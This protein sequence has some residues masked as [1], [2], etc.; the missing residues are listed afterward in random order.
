MLQHCLL[1]KNLMHG[2][3][4]LRSTQTL[5]HYA[6]GMQKQGTR[7]RHQACGVLWGGHNITGIVANRKCS[8]LLRT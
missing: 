6:T 7:E 1:D 8:V 5:P 4:W 2:I 3:L